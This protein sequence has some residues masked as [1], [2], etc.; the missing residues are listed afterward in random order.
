MAVP[1]TVG[2]QFGFGH[3]KL[4][5]NSSELTAVAVCAGTIRLPF[6]VEV[7]TDVVVVVSCSVNGSTRCPPGFVHVP[8]NVEVTAKFTVAFV[9]PTP[10]ISVPVQVTVSPLRVHTGAAS[11]CAKCA[12]CGAFSKLTVVTAS[13]GTAARAVTSS[14]STAMMPIFL[15]YFPSFVDLSSLTCRSSAAGDWDWEATSHKA[16]PSRNVYH[17]PSA[18]SSPRLP[19]Q[20]DLVDALPSRWMTV[21]QLTTQSS[22]L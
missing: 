5:K 17:S 22:M 4:A 7:T 19:S 15:I 1:L 14:D 12:P 21:C 20:E 8:V 16:H 2:V 3:S 13:A 9:L 18:I 11:P 6:L 10:W